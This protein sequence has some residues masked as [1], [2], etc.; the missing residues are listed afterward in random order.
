[1]KRISKLMVNLI[2]GIMLA[3]SCFCLVGCEDIVTLEVTLSVYDYDNDTWYDEQDTTLTIDLYRHLADETVD[4]IVS[5]VKDG[6]YDGLPFYSMPY[7]NN[8]LVMIGDYKLEGA[9]LVQNEIKPVIENGEFEHGATKGSNLKN[10]KGAVGLWRTWYAQDAGGNAHKA[11]N[12]MDTGRANWYLPTTAIADYDGYFCIFGQIDLEDETNSTALSAIEQALK[13][14]SNCEEY[15]VYYTN[16]ENYTVDNTVQNNGLTFNYMSKTEFDEKY[17]KNPSVSTLEDNGIFVPEND[18]Y[19][20]YE[21][22]TVRI[23]VKDG[24]LGAKIKSIK[25][26]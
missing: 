9:N 22:H 6:Y 3:I 24:A 15:V 19:V 12:G 18:Q 14:A 2:A 1:M 4:T 13:T 10:V 21:Y 7:D 23:A 20:C 11:S 17:G 5:Y 25:V 8:K 16:G 26:K